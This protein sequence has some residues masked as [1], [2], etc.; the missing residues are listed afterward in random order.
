MIYLGSLSSGKDRQI[1]KASTYFNVKKKNEQCHVNE[2][3]I[4]F[5]K[6]IFRLPCAQN[7]RCRVLSFRNDFSI[8]C[9]PLFDIDTA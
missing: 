4:S 3:S 9:L 6:L 1:K 2:F 8:K 7:F 5:Q